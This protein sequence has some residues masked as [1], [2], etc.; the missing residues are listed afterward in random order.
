MGNRQACETQRAIQSFHQRDQGSV[1]GRERE[2]HLKG[3]ASRFG[4]GIDLTRE[5]DGEEGWNPIWREVNAVKRKR[6]N[7]R[8]RAIICIAWA[9]A[10]GDRTDVLL[11]IRHLL[12]K[13]LEACLYMYTVIHTAQRHMCMASILF[14]SGEMGKC[15]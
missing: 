10:G 11:A 13:A 14:M 1:A 8:R 9:L 6:D 7:V 3:E 2:W 12:V 4:E 15:T 5:S